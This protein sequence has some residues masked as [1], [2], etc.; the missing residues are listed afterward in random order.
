MKLHTIPPE[1]LG[2]REWRA[3]FDPEGQ[4]GFGKTENE[5]ILDL[6]LGLDQWEAHPDDAKLIERAMSESDQL[7]A[8]P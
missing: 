2:C 8:R 4:Q 1:P 3:Y 7:E 5:A 6:V